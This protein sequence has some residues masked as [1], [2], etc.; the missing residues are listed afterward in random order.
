M[1]FSNIIAAQSIIL[2][3]RNMIFVFLHLQTNLPIINARNRNLFKPV[4]IQIKT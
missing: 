3:N 4:G 1:N 2:V